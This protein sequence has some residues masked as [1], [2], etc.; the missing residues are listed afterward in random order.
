MRISKP[1][2]AVILACGTSLSTQ[3][4]VPSHAAPAKESAPAKAHTP[5][6]APAQ[7]A[8][9]LR[10]SAPVAITGE[11]VPAVWPLSN[12][13]F[14]EDELEAAWTWT[15][16]LDTGKGFETR[17]AFQV[18]DARNYLM[19]RLTGNGKH[20]SGRFWRV[21]NGKVEKLGEPDTTVA[22]ASPGGQL[23]LQRSAW[24]I[25]ALWNGRVLVTAASDSSGGRFAVAT[26]QAKLGATRMQPVGEPPFLRDDFMRAQGPDDPEVPGQWH[27]VSGVWKTSG[28]LNP[29][30]DA[31]MNPNPFV[32]RAAA[33]SGSKDGGLKT[34][35]SNSGTVATV[36]KWFWSDYSVATALRANGNPRTASLV[37]GVAAY[38][39]SDGSGI[40]GIIDFRSGR[41]S[42]K[43]GNRVLATSQPFYP[44]LDQWHRV[45]LDPGPGLL[46]LVVDGVERVRVHVSST[47]AAQAELAQGELAQGEAAL[48]AEVGG[49]NF[50]DFDDVRIGPND[51]I[52]DDFRTTSVGQ[53]DDV[54]GTW[55][56]RPGAQAAS[57]DAVGRRSKTS[58]GRGLTLT[59][60]RE[61]TEGKVEAKF[62][63][64]TVTPRPQGTVKGVGV[65]FA[66]RDANN[67]FLA[68]RWNNDLQI[69]EYSKGLGKVLASV[70]DLGTKGDSPLGNLAFSVEWRDGVIA[71]RRGTAMATASVSSIP[72]GRVGA[73]I[74]G[75]TD[76]VAL[77]SFRAMGAAPSWGEV[78]LPERFTKDTLMQNWASNAA[79]W[80]ED[81]TTAGETFKGTRWHT[82][83][84]FGDIA[85]SLPLPAF[86]S[87]KPN[88]R[89]S[90][91]LASSPTAPATGSR[92]EA[93]RAESGLLLRLYQDERLISSTTAKPGAGDTLRFVRRPVGADA[94]N[95]RVALG[96]AVVFNETL[97]GAASSTQSAQT[98][99]GV[100]A[101]ELAAF[102]WEKVRATTSNVVDYSFTSAPVDWRAG[103]GRWNVSERWTCS[104]QW[105]FFAGS[106][107]IAPTL[108]S[109]F[110]TRGDW[111][112]EAYLATPMDVTRGERSPTDL[113]LTVEGDGRD[114]ASG[115]SFLFGANGRTLNRVLRGDRIVQEKPFEM[116]GSNTHQDWFYVRLERRRVG[117]A[118]QFRYSINGQEVWK[119]TDEQS[120]KSAL[121]EPRHLAFWTYNGGLSV[122]RVRLWHS[123]LQEGRDNLGGREYS[124]E[125][126]TYLNTLGEW[127]LHNE[128]QRLADGLRPVS[129]G[130]HDALRISNSQS[131]GD[132]SLYV[133]QQPFEAT[134]HPVLQWDY[135]VPEDVFIN[136]YAKIGGAWREITF[137]GA[138]ARL[139]A[140]TGT[141]PKT[142]TAAGAARAVPSLG[143]VENVV[144]DGKWHSARFNLLDALK[145][146]GLSTR[147]E[148]LAFSAPDSGY[149]RA[150]LGGNHAG[151]TYWLSS[152]QAPR[153]TTLSA[154]AG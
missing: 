66:A 76:A 124:D 85:L 15:A 117:N 48:M 154:S 122:A 123:G 137:S 88:Q 121:D 1:Y 125:A 41:A 135:R 45:F 99:T 61:R 23:T 151:A 49:A 63:P 18:Q 64:A 109:R 50:I 142:E 4:N 42:I 82:G 84:F 74:E 146:A 95:L 111:T 27:R 39:Q 33:A 56:T 13:S 98:R 69:V 21:A 97:K 132:W 57:K 30:A 108:W 138:T 71:A 107:S 87:S 126:P 114:L 139:A 102:D 120:G 28:L 12:F 152:F 53:W 44:E 113:N 51:A 92:L 68:R 46:R 89:L 32:F 150:G 17:I 34:G 2:L 112:M 81:K 118:L 91:L 16:H 127:R 78:I 19:L 104:P 9:P 149:L 105:G 130:G 37:A 73:W 35:S 65:A 31:T 90:L 143:I 83:D 141:N 59:G 134:V 70:P 80:R 75:A 110:A 54:Q 14:D 58:A 79:S 3:G 100:Q 103:R 6:K 86:T 25:R 7:T 10:K 77:Q 55:Q 26:R 5:A 119:Y 60:S 94:V 67:Y 93:E 38:R 36:G 11:V 8:T 129:D 22:L 131:G 116:I 133:T 40:Q 24:R 106:D 72:A 144:T 62:T 147:V 148:A 140:R 145:A 43:A 20:I 128:G 153:A 96:N 52:S 101:R 136:L 47:Q 29:Q 115:Y